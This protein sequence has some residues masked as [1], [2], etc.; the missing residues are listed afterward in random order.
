MD[1]KDLTKDDEITNLIPDIGNELRDAPEKTLAC[2]GLAVHQ[3]N[4]YFVQ[5]FI[6][7]KARF[8]RASTFF[9]KILSFHR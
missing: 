8:H 6:T 4:I 5:P 1:F 2:M 9:K 3:V 7:F